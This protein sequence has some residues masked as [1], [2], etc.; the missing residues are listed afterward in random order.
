MLTD[1]YF[2]GWHSSLQRREGKAFTLV[3]PKLV[4]GN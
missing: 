2:H 3:P 4:I 1:E